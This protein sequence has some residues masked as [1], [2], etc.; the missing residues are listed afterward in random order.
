LQFKLAYEWKNN[1]VRFQ[2]LTT[3]DCIVA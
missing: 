3:T 1:Y 2:I